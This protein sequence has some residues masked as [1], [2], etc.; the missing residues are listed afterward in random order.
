MTSES[1]KPISWKASNVFFLSADFYPALLNAKCYDVTLYCNNIAYIGLERALNIITWISCKSRRELRQKYSFCNFHITQIACLLCIIFQ[2]RVRPCKIYFASSVLYICG[3]SIY[4]LVSRGHHPRLVYPSKVFINSDF[5]NLINLKPHVCAEI[6]P[7]NGY[8]N[9]YRV[10]FYSNLNISLQHASRNRD[11]K[12]YR[13][14]YNYSEILLFR[15]YN[16][17]IKNLLRICMS[18]CRIT[19]SMLSKLR[20]TYTEKIVFSF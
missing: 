1:W 14:I 7:Y 8:R 17:E 10:R 9:L 16:W 11:T 2:L 15:S 13:L 20:D 6:F 3:V 12:R 18:I 5:Y 19:R 4:F